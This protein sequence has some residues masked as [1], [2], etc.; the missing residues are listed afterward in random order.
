M[1]ARGSGRATSERAGQ[2]PVIFGCQAERGESASLKS[3][4]CVRTVG[5][6]QLDRSQ[7]LLS[8]AL[9]AREAGTGVDGA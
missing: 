5:F 4:V 2:A 6:G 8:H 9:A 7:P 3:T 1:H